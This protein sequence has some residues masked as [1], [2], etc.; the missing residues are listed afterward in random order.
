MLQPLSYHTQPPP[1]HCPGCTPAPPITTTLPPRGEGGDC[2]RAGGSRLL[3]Q[4][5]TYA[6]SQQHPACALQ[7]TSLLSAAPRHIHS[8]PPRGLLHPC[9]APSLCHS[10]SSSLAPCS[11]RATTSTQKHALSPLLATACLHSGGLVLC[12]QSMLFMLLP[13]Q[14]PSP[15]AA[16]T[17]VTCSN[18]GAPAINTR[19]AAAAAHSSRRQNRSVQ[20]HACVWCGRCQALAQTDRLRLC[21]LSG[22]KCAWG[23]T[24][25]RVTHL[26]FWAEQ[27]LLIRD[28]CTH[29]RHSAAQHS[30]A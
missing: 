12:T 24:P 30:M 23:A 11:H 1:W 3:C 26:V 19:P 25:A 17:A 18:R 2:G 14:W 10:N 22:A 9:I 4:Q 13:P 20:T 27:C 6:S 7:H 21:P 15:S 8:P 29:N 16:P 5:V 28:T